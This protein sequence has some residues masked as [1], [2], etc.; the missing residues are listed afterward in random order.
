MPRPSPVFDVVRELFQSGRR[1]SWSLQEL[2]EEAASRLGGAD[3]S[4]VFRAAQTLER[5]GVVAKIDVGD[6]KAR[7]EL[8]DDHHEHVRC[9]SC[10]RVAEV[11]GCSLDDVER[12]V[13]QST[14][15][16][17]LSHHLTFTGLCPECAT[18]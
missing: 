4:S 2:H 1:H 9:D 17:V 3:Y 12:T 7:F 16:V 13:R 18:R 10:G 5:E 8:S 15:Y 14:G 6:G 11:P